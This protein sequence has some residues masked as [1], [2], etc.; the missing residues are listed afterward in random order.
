MKRLFLGLV[1]MCM[2]SLMVLNLLS[3]IIGGVWLVLT[4][5]WTIVV[6]GLI[7]SVI[8]PW[9]YSLALLP[10]LLLVPFLVKAIDK[11]WRPLVGTLSFVISGYGN[12]VLTIWVIFV[13]SWVLSYSSFNILP[14]LLWGFSTMMGPIGYMAL[15]EGRD[16]SLGTSIATL[17]VQLMYFLLCL[18]LYLLNVFGF[19]VPIWLVILIFTSATSVM[20]ITSF[21]NTKKEEQ[22]ET[23]VIDR[24][25]NI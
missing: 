20:G 6:L 16:A 7:Y 21:L 13:F 9:G 10:N 1:V 24:E 8:M 15:K 5:G 12:V 4:G 3:G 18:N 25:T 17:F 19:V 2:S 23:G 14:L 11:K 22:I